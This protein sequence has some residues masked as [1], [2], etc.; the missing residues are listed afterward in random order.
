MHTCAFIDT[1]F[2]VNSR[3][4]HSIWYWL[5]FQYSAT[6][7]QLYSVLH[8]MR[9]KTLHRERDK[10][11]CFAKVK[12]IRYYNVICFLYHLSLFHPGMKRAMISTFYKHHIA[13]H[14]GVQNLC[15]LEL[16]HGGEIAQV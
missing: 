4:F 3:F 12:V 8:A 5:K 1:F 16:Y 7:E 10:K 2:S 11:N 13:L 9:R 6:T 14:F 15:S